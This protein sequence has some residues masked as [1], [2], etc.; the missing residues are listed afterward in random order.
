MEHHV[1]ISH[2][3]PRSNQL[4]GSYMIGGFAVEWL[5]K[6]NS[7]FAKLPAVHF[8]GEITFDDANKKYQE[9]TCSHEVG[10]TSSIN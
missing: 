1:E 4:L 7:H 9:K 5:Q 2:L 8:V 6:Q 3:F 10:L